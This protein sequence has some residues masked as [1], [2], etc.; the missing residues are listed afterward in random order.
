MV[1]AGTEIYILNMTRAYFYTLQKKRYPL[2]LGIKLVW[3]R[4]LRLDSRELFKLLFL[5]Q[6]PMWIIWVHYNVET[7]IYV[8][9]QI[10]VGWEKMWRVPGHERCAKLGQPTVIMI[11]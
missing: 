6:Q 9:G 3:W 7:L 5:I 4:G 1:L 10:W 11:G 2:V 8:D